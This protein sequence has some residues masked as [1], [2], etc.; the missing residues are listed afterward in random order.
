MPSCSE[1]QRVAQRFLSR[2]RDIEILSKQ[3]TSSLIN[4]IEMTRDEN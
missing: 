2:T 1:F 4:L 3:L